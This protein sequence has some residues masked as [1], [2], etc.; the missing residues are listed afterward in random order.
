MNRNRRLNLK[1]A[2]VTRL[3]WVRKSEKLPLVTKTVRKFTIGRIDEGHLIPFVVTD[4]IE[5]V[6][7]SN[8]AL[9]GHDYQHRMTNYLLELYQTLHVFVCFSARLHDGPYKCGERT[10]EG[11][12]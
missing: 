2:P 12:A 11:S 10:R 7:N 6:N 9:R 1:T 5:Q 8:V 3:Y 4:P